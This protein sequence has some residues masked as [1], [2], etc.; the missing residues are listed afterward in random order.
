MIALSIPWVILLL[1]FIALLCALR[2]KF[3]YSA[4]FVF[5]ALVLN[6]YSE[7]FAL[8]FACCSDTTEEKVFRVMSWNVNAEPSTSKEDLEEIAEMICS[9][10]PDVVFVAEPYLNASDTMTHLLSGRYPYTTYVNQECDRGHYVYSK[11]RL[12]SHEFIYQSEWNGLVLKTMAYVGADSVIIYGCH[13]ASNNYDAEMK[14]MTPD[15]VATTRN[16]LQYLK[17]IQRASAIR[18]EECDSIVY[19]MR[20]YDVP[21]I[22]MGDMNDVCGSPCMKVFAEA[23]LHDAWWE[24]GFGYGATLHHPLPYRIDHVMY[25]VKKGSSCSKGSSGLKLMGIR[26]VPNKGLSDH[27]AL[28]AD[29]TLHR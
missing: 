25:G 4:L 5:S 8:H 6:W 9:E 11:F 29:F 21:T 16:A 27:D 12:D 24:G 19:D 1:L 15:S 28:V 17:N 2:R 13:L 10:D 26:K 18:E 3:W 14:Y 22:V 23:G 7:C 20:K